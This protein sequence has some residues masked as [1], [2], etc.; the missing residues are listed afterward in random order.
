MSKTSSQAKNRWNEKNYDRITIMVKK[1]KKEEWKQ[2]AKDNGFSSLNS[3]LIDCIENKILVHDY[4]KEKIGED[5]C[6]PIIKI[7]DK[8]EDIDINELP[9]KF[10]RFKSPLPYR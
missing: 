4:V 2:K 5:I 9:D 10:V 1:G 3:Y 6:V 7:Y 8:P